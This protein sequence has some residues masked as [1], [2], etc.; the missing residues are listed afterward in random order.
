MLP[1]LHRQSADLIVRE[2]LEFAGCVAAEA[3]GLPNASVAAAADSALDRRRDLAGPLTGLRQQAGLPADPGGDTAFRHL[4]LCF[5]PPSFDGPGARFPPTARFFAH[6]S[7][8]TPHQD[9]PPW[10]DQ[11]AGRP[12]VLVSMGTV[13]HRTPGRYMNGS[14]LVSLRQNGAARSRRPAVMPGC[15]PGRP[16]ESVMSESESVSLVQAASLEIS[17]PVA[18]TMRQAGALD[19]RF[20]AD[21][22]SRT[23]R[24]VIAAWA[25]AAE[26]DDTALAAIAEPRAV[27]SLMH[28]DQARWQV[29]PGPRVTQIKILGLEADRDPPRFRVHFE[30]AG[31]RQ[32]ADPTHVENA[33]GDPTF[34]GMLERRRRPVT[35]PWTSCGQPSTRGRE[36]PSA[37]ETGSPRCSGWTSSSC[38]TSLPDRSRV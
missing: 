12:T 22:V 33:D 21:H 32:F 14:L 11:P 3:L 26:G 20:S 23:A 1:A 17:A 16:R 30:F 37:R 35:R 18:E 24:Q 10:L 8:P 25:T 27:Y 5:T 9:L 29:I 13:F 2:S 4:H 36:G 31:H 15:D 34:V 28:P 19:D 6:H 38:S 7:T